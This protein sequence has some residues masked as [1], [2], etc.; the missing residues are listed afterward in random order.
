MME[1]DPPFPSRFFKQK[2]LGSGFTG[3]VWS[4][5][6]QE[7]AGR[8][9][10]VKT[11]D[12]RLYAKHRLAFPPLEASLG[13]S[14]NHPNVARLLE[15]LEEPERIFLVQEHL[16]GGDLFSCMQESG[17]FSEFLARCCFGD[18]MA[19]VAY[20]HGCGIVHRDLK[21]SSYLCL[22]TPSS[23]RSGAVYVAVAVGLRFF[24]F[25]LVLTVSDQPEN[26]V[27]DATGTLKIV[28]FGLATRYAPG[29]L[30][31]EYCG[32]PEYAAPEVLRE[33][34]HEGPP[35]DVWATGVML[36]DM[37]MGCL[38]FEAMPETFD[39]PASLSAEV[40]SELVDLLRLILHE[41]AAARGSCVQVLRS[42]WMKLPVCLGEHSE[43][44]LVSQCENS[45]ASSSGSSS[46]SMSLAADSPLRVRVTR[47][48]NSALQ[49]DMGFV[50]EVRSKRPARNLFLK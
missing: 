14:L 10:A 39:L 42:D 20:I 25:S 48:R 47:E 2:K 18:I 33:T 6:D 40:S 38:P 44:E 36:Y 15:T 3:D 34:P 30:L 27:L 49:R 9:V 1:D 45:T 13:K 29:Q 41:D 7:H 4:A 31:T 32:S 21:V 37:V 46:G 24:C 5:K 22:L 12:R 11:L 23:E 50:Q 26:C 43:L 19:A 16:T 8:L 17:V 28:D 35:V